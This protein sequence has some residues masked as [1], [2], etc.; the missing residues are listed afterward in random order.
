MAAISSGRAAAARRE[1]ADDPSFD[2]TALKKHN[3]MRKHE[4][5]LL[6]QIRTGK[7]GLR[8]FLFQRRVPTVTS[9]YCSCSEA[10]PEAT[11][12]QRPPPEPPD[13]RGHPAWETAAHITLHCLSYEAER[14]D[15]QNM[16]PR[17]IR[18]TRDLAEITSSEGAALTLVRWFLRLGRLKE[19]RLAIRLAWPE[20]GEAA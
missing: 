12:L 15:L 11:P 14:R 3:G 17:P 1:P 16:L 19:Y 9:P 4:S 18:T 8:A 7:I 20:E 2:G 5:S 6:T 10:T 13:L